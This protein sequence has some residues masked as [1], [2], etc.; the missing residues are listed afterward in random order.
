MLQDVNPVTCSK[1][2]S[3]KITIKKVAVKE[4]LERDV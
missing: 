4:N 2:R 3:F 1:I